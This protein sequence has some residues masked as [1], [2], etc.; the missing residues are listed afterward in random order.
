[1]IVCQSFCVFTT[2]GT[3]PPSLSVNTKISY[4]PEYWKS[5]GLTNDVRYKIAILAEKS[6]GFK[7]RK[8]TKK[9]ES[10]GYPLE[11]EKAALTTLFSHKKCQHVY[12]FLIR[13]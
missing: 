10:T 12:N 6:G 8:A 11:F 7:S 2:N 4:S 1:M 13:T 9:G 5:L 3:V